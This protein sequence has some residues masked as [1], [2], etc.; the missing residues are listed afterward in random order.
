[1]CAKCLMMTKWQQFYTDIFLVGFFCRFVSFV[2]SKSI[3]PSLSLSLAVPLL[4]W[5]SPL[6]QRI[7][8]QIFARHFDSQPHTGTL[9]VVSQP[10]PME[11]CL[12]F[13]Y[14]QNAAYQH[15]HPTPEGPTQCSGP[16]L[17]GEVFIIELTVPR[18]HSRE[19]TQS[20]RSTSSW[21][22]YCRPAIKAESEAVGGCMWRGETPA[23]PWS[24]RPGRHRRGGVHSRA[25]QRRRE[26][27]N[28]TSRQEGVH[29]KTP[30]CQTSIISVGFTA[31]KKIL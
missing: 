24:S 1:M 8:N 17:S 30:L 21:L 13:K 18:D 4:F 16:L 19:A 2:S 5:I 28:E 6:L 11:P 20:R 25:L 26:L 31:S 22:E 9:Y 23:G 15:L 12:H 27:I 7:I 14:K 29:S 10:D 3:S